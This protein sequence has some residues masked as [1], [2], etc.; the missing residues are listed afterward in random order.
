[1]ISDGELENL[2]QATSTLRSELAKSRMPG[3]INLGNTCFVNSVLQC[4]GHT[5][6]LVE[7]CFQTGHGRNCPRKLITSLES[8]LVIPFT[9]S[10]YKSF[11]KNPALQKLNKMPF[12]GFCLFGSH[13]RAVH[14]FA[15]KG[16]D[17]VIPLAVPSLIK[18][19]GWEGQFEL[20]V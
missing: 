4:F 14:V 2:R 3:F 11:K 12:C 16:V 9:E 17:E 1:M 5:P 15:N 18:N 10:N 13:I 6:Y 8:D 19:V 7:Y 20:G